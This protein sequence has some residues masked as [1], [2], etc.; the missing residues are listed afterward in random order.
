M[1]IGRLKLGGRDHPDLSMQAALIEPADVLERLVL[2][3]IETTPG[4]TVDQ[5]GL[6]QTVKDS[7]SAL[8]YESPREPTEVTAPAAAIRSV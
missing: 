3:V 8:S 4:L 6:V 1:V 7:A 2:D 5:L